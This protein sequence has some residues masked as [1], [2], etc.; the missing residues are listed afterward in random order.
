MRPRLPGGL[1]RHRDFRN[2]WAAETISVFG[3]QFTAFALPLV[4]VIL[5]DAS[6]FAV[7]AL[8][9]IEFLPFILFAIPAGVWVDRMRRKPILVAGDLAR[10]VLLVSLPI[11][12]AFDALTLPHLYAVGFLVGICTVFFDVAYQSYLPS[13]VER[14]QLV[15]GNSK[16]EISRSTSQ[17]AGPGAAGGIVSAL[18]A[19]VAILL[20]A[21]S[22]VVSAFFL[23]AIR[24]GEELPERAE[25]VARPSMLADAKEGL[26]FVLR[27]RYLRAISLCTATSN[28]F[29]SMAQALLVVYAVREL[30]M[31]PAALGLAFSLGNAGPLLAAFTTNRISSRLGVGPTIL[32]TSMVFPLALLPLP[33]ATSS[34]PLPFLV[35][36]VAVGGF[37]AVAYNITQVSFRQAICPER[38]QGRMNAVIR[39]MVW[40]TMPVGALVGGALGTWIGLR[41]AITVAAVGALF[42]FLPILLSPV[43][44]LREMPKPVD[45]P[46]PSEAEAAGGLLPA[47]A[48]GTPTASE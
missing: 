32:A 48:G 37:A 18:G 1:W 7:S 3:S 9:V 4:A 25:G 11:A 31:S 13:L 23:F 19:P 17:L 34:N 5:L 22:Y 36:S 24:K 29:W 38:L 33:L 14:G 8:I 2:L 39:F 46:L 26:G 45:E 42:S 47:P 35:V 6:P 15:E 12:Y 10:A 20:D 44:K 16:L 30:D 28:L 43:P 27:N 41:P 40:G 21:I